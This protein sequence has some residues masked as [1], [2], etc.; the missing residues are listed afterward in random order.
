[1]SQDIIID[2]FLTEFGSDYEKVKSLYKNRELFNL[3]KIDFD[4]VDE[5]I[6]KIIV[7]NYVYEK[8]EDWI[9]NSHNKRRINLSNSS[10]GQ[11]EALPMVLVLAVLPFM[12]QTRFF[13]IE[14]PE[15]HLFPQSQKYI[16][17]LI[18]LIFNL[19]DKK[20]KFLIT[21]HS[22]YILTAFNNLIQA[23]NT[24][25]ALRKKSENKSLIQKLIKIIPENRMLDIS[26][27]GVYTIQDGKIKSI[28]NQE[29][30]LIDTNIIDDISNEFSREF[31]ELLELELGE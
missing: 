26:D 1:M 7:G 9:Y 3:Q 5:L 4:A 24:L 28:I 16:V 18:S 13:I 21:T 29:N 22:P 23:G 25:Q 30:Q 31:D 10:S 17:N 14:E 11:Q 12:T 8:G 2:Y 15:A 6:N 20:H 19:T 27:I